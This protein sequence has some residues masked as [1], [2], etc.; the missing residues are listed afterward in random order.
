MN[1]YILFFLFSLLFIHN[2]FTQETQ[3]L[4]L[5]T[6]HFSFP[7]RD[8]EKIEVSNQID[9]LLPQ[10][11]NE[12]EIIVEKLS[13]FNPTAIAIE[14]NSSR[15]HIIDSIYNEYL[16]G[17]HDLSRQEHEQ[18][19]FR[20]AKKLN[21]TKLYCVDDWGRNYKDIDS[22][23]KDEQ[24]PIRNQF[25]ESF[26]KNPDSLLMYSK[27]DVYKS[28]GIL[29]QLK[30]SNN[31]QHHEKNLGNYLISIFKFETKEYPYYGA[32]FTTGWW[33]NRNLRIFRNIQKISTSSNDKILVIYGTGHLNLLNIFFNSSPEYNLVDTSTY[34]D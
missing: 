6:F 17:A 27:E 12:I 5:G 10:Y 26:S 22:I 24:S 13:R 15:Q 19:G 16:K 23:F 4:T 11:Q 2:S 7:N 20:L 21:L 18:I 29:A 25:M 3:I 1:R 33:F 34:L 8:I 14:V 28:K 30:A 32:D 9:V 31:M